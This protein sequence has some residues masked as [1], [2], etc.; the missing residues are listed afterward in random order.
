MNWAILHSRLAGAGVLSNPSAGVPDVE[1]TGVCQDSRKVHSGYAFTAVS[2]RQTNGIRF[3]QQA[4][5]AGARVIISE[6]DPGGIPHLVQVSDA[7]KASAVIAA[8]FHGDPATSLQLTG[9]TGTNGKTTTGTL[10]QHVLES[11]GTATGM[12]GTVTYSTGKTTYTPQLTTPDATELHPMF[13]EMVK[14]GCKAC[15]VEVSSHALDQAR[16]ATLNFS[17]GIFTN[18]MHDHLDYHKT[19]K[20]YLNTKKI[21]FDDL[22]PQAVAVYNHDDQ[23]G[24]RMVEDTQAEPCSFG[25][26][27]DADIQFKIIDDHPSGLRLHLDGQTCSFRLAG[28]FNAYNLAAAYGAARATGLSGTEVIEALEEAGP[29]CGRFEQF[30]CD[31]ATRIVID[32]AH[33]PDALEQVLKSLAHVQPAT[34]RLWCI[35]GCGGMRDQS[36]RPLMGRVAERLANEVVLTNDNPRN[37]SAQAIIQDILEGM[38]TPERVHRILSRPDAIRYVAQSCSSGDIVLVAGKGHESWQTENGRQIPMKDQDLIL[39]AFAPYN[40]KPLN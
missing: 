18:L 37:E 20:H 26:S 9:I 21:L 19:M 4:L 31:D 30:V 35:F 3:I 28:A 17:V 34:A 33:T 5:D 6:E 8:A 16:T 27:A 15:V 25:Q 13:A 1:V 11:T 14:S 40:P 24:K 22:S 32:F 38:K 7:R 23:M 29:V 39:K 36:K 10:V 12:I 2:G